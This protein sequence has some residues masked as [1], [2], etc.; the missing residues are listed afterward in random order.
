MTRTVAL[1]LGIRPPPFG[2]LLKDGELSTLGLRPGLYTVAAARL[3]K[4]DSV[5]SNFLRLHPG[6]RALTW[7]LSSR[8]GCLDTARLGWADGRSSLSSS[9]SRAPVAPAKEKAQLSGEA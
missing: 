4:A 1:G 5:S 2:G 3:C 9:R 8:R 6:R 7:R